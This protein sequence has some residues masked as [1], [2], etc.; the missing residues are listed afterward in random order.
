VAECTGL[1]SRHTRK[2]IGGSN[3]PLSANRLEGPG[4]VSRVDPAEALAAGRPVLDAVLVP[5]GFAYVVGEAGPSS[6]GPFARAAYVAWDRR[7]DLS[8][9]Y[10]LGLVT[11][12]FGA[13]S[14]LHEELMRA[15][16]RGRQESAF[17]G[18]D[19]DPLRAFEHLAEDL[20]GPAGLFVRGDKTRFLELVAW[21]SANPRPRGFRAIH[22]PGPGAGNERSA[23]GG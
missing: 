8:V 1:L 22:A 17:P 21:A 11:Y 12:S 18:F 9:R 4:H 15:A 2:G 6:G 19:K 16:I 5:A 23:S 7:L 10:E 14:L 13:T 20:R 3:P